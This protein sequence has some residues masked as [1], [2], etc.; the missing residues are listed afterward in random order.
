MNCIRILFS[1][2]PCYPPKV[3]ALS[4]LVWPKIASLVDV[5]TS[6]YPPGQLPKSVGLRLAYILACS[7]PL[8]VVP[9]FQYLFLT[10]HF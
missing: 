4:A 6:S 1:T 7:I 2:R 10:S 9:P 3:T 5:V 8:S